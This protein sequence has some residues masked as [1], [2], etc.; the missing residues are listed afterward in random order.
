MYF[1][2]KNLLEVSLYFEYEMVYKF[3]SIKSDKYF[4]QL[5]IFISIN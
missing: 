3:N 2:L 5:S 1:I 4:P